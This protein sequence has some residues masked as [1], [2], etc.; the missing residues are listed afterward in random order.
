MFDKKGHTR[1]QSEIVGG[2][3]PKSEGFA[4]NFAFGSSSGLQSPSRSGA[5]SPVRGGQSPTLMPTSGNLLQPP[6]PVMQKGTAAPTPSGVQA[7]RGHAHRRSAAMSSGDVMSLMLSQNV[8]KVSKS[9]SAPTSPTALGS[10]TYFD[11]QESS[12]S[13]QSSH[14]M[15]PT[16]L[17]TPVSLSTSVSTPDLSMEFESRKSSTEDAPRKSRVTFM[18]APEIIPRPASA[19]TMSTFNTA[20]GG[21]ISSMASFAS[22]LETHKQEKSAFELRAGR[23]ASA[24]DAPL[25]LEASTPRSSKRPTSADASLILNA[26]SKASRLFPPLSP[27]DETSKSKKKSKGHSKTLSESGSIT[28]KSRT[29]DGLPGSKKHK[30]SVK[31]WAGSILL[32]RSYRKRALP[33]RSP[34]PPLMQRDDIQRLMHGG[35]YVLMPSTNSG[36]SRHHSVPSDECEFQPII[37]LGNFDETEQQDDTTTASDYPTIDLDAA[38]GPFNSPTSPK[39]KATGFGAA[40]HRMHSA[41]IYHRRAES[42]PEMQLFSLAEDEIEDDRMGDVFEDSEDDE[43]DDDNSDNNDTTL[44]TLVTQHSSSWNSANDME[45]T[46]DDSERQELDLLDGVSNVRK[47]S[48]R[49]VSVVSEEGSVDSI[50]DHESMDQPMQINEQ[51]LEQTAKLTQSAFETQSSEQ[52]AMLLTPLLACRVSEALVTTPASVTPCTS[53]EHP[54]MQS[55]NTTTESLSIATPPVQ[56]SDL[57]YPPQFPSILDDDRSITSAPSIYEDAMVLGEPGPEMRMSISVDDIPATNRSFSTHS[58][59]LYPSVVNISSATMPGI[60]SGS[61]G[62]GS[63]ASK[64]NKSKDKKERRWSKV[65]NFWKK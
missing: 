31:G 45:W 55:T 54:F 7:R 21:S 59:G 25:S 3:R 16:D 39:N 41:A 2:R 4:P 48:R 14:L 28:L 44:R 65:F 30:S 11:R 32:R 8:S 24:S 51:Y 53:V 46:S 29:I 12:K 47:D 61:R 13:N 19:G 52:K 34:T 64:D 17:L 40:R 62:S 15:P 20:Q 27:K 33:R 60:I 57:L 42:M 43:D 18:D 36:Q 1:R 10:P 49:K 9:G 50:L 38:L 56:K 58:V 22:S 5:S 63:I 26:A 23:R 37:D 6:T 35:S